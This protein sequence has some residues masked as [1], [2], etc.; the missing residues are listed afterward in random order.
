M[1]TASNTVSYTWNVANTG[2][3]KKWFV[4]LCHNGSGSWRGYAGKHSPRYQT[5]TLYTLC[6][7]HQSRCRALSLSRHPD[8]TCEAGLGAPFNSNRAQCA[9]GPPARKPQ[10][11]GHLCHP[12]TPGLPLRGGRRSCTSTWASS[13][14]RPA[15]HQQLVLPQR[16]LFL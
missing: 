9:W 8:L 2:Q 1:I 14:Y 6:H 3:G 7:L 11:C 12:G 13:P 16:A 15:Q 10:H 5:D 4:S